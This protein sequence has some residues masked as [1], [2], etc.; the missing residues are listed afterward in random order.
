[1]FKSPLSK[2]LLRLFSKEKDIYI[3]FYQSKEARRENERSNFLH[4]T[5]NKR[6]CQREA[7]W[8]QF[9]DFQ[10]C[11]H[12]REGCSISKPSSVI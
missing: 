9:H 3:G 4:L 1:M 12:E 5:S 10:L 2:I 6:P 8:L 11:T 7:S